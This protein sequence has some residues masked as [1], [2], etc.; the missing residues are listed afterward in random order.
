M[1]D[2]FDTKRLKHPGHGKPKAEGKFKPTDRDIETSTD[3]LDLLVGS[4]LSLA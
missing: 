2:T 4:I 3:F 1:S